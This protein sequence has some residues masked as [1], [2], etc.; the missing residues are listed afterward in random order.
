MKLGSSDGALYISYI[1]ATFLTIPQILMEWD[2]LFAHCDNIWQTLLGLVIVVG[3]WKVYE[4]SGG[5]GSSL[6][7]VHLVGGALGLAIF[8]VCCSIYQT[9]R[10]RT[11]VSGDRTS[12]KR[13]SRSPSLSASR[14]SSSK[15]KCRMP[16][17]N[18]RPLVWIY[19]KNV[20]E[21]CMDTLNLLDKIFVKI[22]FSP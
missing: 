20:S 14:S 2:H 19:G 18:R 10:L 5:R 12:C 11:I 13:Q 9:D 7:L 21:K 4:M 3:V 8:V 16:K 1:G 17:Y 15:T 6:K 22:I